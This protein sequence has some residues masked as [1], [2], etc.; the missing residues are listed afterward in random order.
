MLIVRIGQGAW[1][2]CFCPKGDKCL[3]Y[4][5]QQPI[6]TSII[7][8]AKPK[9]IAAWLTLIYQNGAVTL[10]LAIL[11]KKAAKTS[12]VLNSDQ[13]TVQ[14]PSLQ[15]QKLLMLHSGSF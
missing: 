10:S 2:C 7:Q 3:I 14:V 5:W 8:D 15:D 1:S 6:A 13:I 12:V 4:G 9:I 11:P